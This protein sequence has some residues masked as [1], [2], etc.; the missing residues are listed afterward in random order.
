M[1]T[2]LQIQQAIASLTAKIEAGEKTGDSPELREMREKVAKYQG[3]LDKT[4]H[5]KKPDPLDQL[6][7]SFAGREKF[8]EVNQFRSGFND[9]IKG[10][11]DIAAFSAEMLKE[12]GKFLRGGGKIPPFGRATEALE[13][14]LYKRTPTNALERAADVAGN[15]APNL[16]TGVGAAKTAIQAGAGLLRAGGAFGSRAATDTIAPAAT[17]FGATEAGVSPLPAAALS[18]LSGGTAN[19]TVQGFGKPQVYKNAPG[20]EHIGQAALRLQNAGY[21]VRA[22][23]GVGDELI[24][25]KMGY[26]PGA[27][28]EGVQAANNIIME[29]AFGSLGKKYGYATPE[30]MQDIA[31]K[32]VQR[33]ED[34]TTKNGA[35]INLKISPKR[36]RV[37]ANLE[38]A[39][40]ESTAGQSPPQVGSNLK[41]RI[42]RKDNPLAQADVETAPPLDGDS[43]ARDIIEGVVYALRGGD[44]AAFMRGEDITSGAKGA[45]EAAPDIVQQWRDGTLPSNTPNKEIPKTL[46]PPPMTAGTLNKIRV[47]M[48]TASVAG[49]AASKTYI[50]GV[51]K[52]IDD[53]LDETPDVSLP[54]LEGGR[55]MYKNNLAFR[56][57]A[58]DN[59]TANSIYTPEQISKGFQKVYGNKH[60]QRKGGDASEFALDLGNIAGG[61]GGETATKANVYARRSSMDAWRQ[62]TIALGGAG[63][64]GVGSGITHGSIGTAAL[65][66]GGVLGAVGMTGASALGRGFMKSNVVNNY[67]ANKGAF[68]PTRG[69]GGAGGAFAVDKI[70]QN[71]Q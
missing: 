49:S 21:P 31:E 15:F 9:F 62:A 58:N 38:K 26:D 34:A 42:S 43:L 69:L 30:A 22:A 20:Q 50:A 8:K 36:V 59:I 71:R 11:G 17:Y 5:A 70:E 18:V 63:L 44:E 14:H 64:V 46:P 6:G 61:R 13:P 45:D 54:E 57:M 10:S 56:A 41:R 32:A 65:G 35:D 19:A 16:L 4:K 12:S 2:A 24:D 47:N 7:D 37:F 48:N 52:A 40:K 25:V 55:K 23:E 3:F 29:K 39:Y 33:M 27:T 1:A 28:P 68:S 66:L 60:A 51:R 53:W 67:Y